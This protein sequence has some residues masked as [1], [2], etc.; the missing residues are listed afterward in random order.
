MDVRRR[1]GRERGKEGGEGE[2]GR[3]GSVGRGGRGRGEGESKGE[4]EW[5]GGWVRREGGRENRE[6]E[7]GRASLV[8]RSYVFSNN[9]PGNKPVPVYLHDRFHQRHSLCTE[10]YTP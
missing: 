2:R 1:G 7:E 4:R 6:I 9:Y 3:E 5:E 8:I 10:K